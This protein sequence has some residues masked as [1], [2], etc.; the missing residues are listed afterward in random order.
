MG[1]GWSDCWSTQNKRGYYK[2][3]FHRPWVE[4]RRTASLLPSHRPLCLHPPESRLPSYSKIL[5]ATGRLA[6]HQSHRPRR[7]PDLLMSTPLPP[8]RDASQPVL[9]PSPTLE[10][11]LH[12]QHQDHIWSQPVCGLCPLSDVSPRDTSPLEAKRQGPFPSH[13]TP[14][15][16]TWALLL[17]CS[18]KSILATN[19]LGLVAFDC[20][21]FF[22]LVV[23]ISKDARC[24]FLDF[25]V[26]LV[27]VTYWIWCY[28]PTVK[29]ESYCSYAFGYTT[30]RVRQCVCYDIIDAEDLN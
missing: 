17:I 8:T 16:A 9:S 2:V 12:H 1:Q 30:Q 4:P 23:R 14:R 24:F 25:L 29:H 5:L 10:L 15:W 22:L 7:W 20:N 18:L 13:P 11:G 27:L 3:R 6:P 28:D 19:N 21:K 26:D